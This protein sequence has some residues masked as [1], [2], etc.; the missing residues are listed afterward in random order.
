MRKDVLEEI[1]RVNDL[2]FV[3]LS[4]FVMNQLSELKSRVKNYTRTMDTFL[5]K[6][7]NLRLFSDDQADNNKGFLL[8][9]SIDDENF[10]PFGALNF[11]QSTARDTLLNALKEDSG[12]IFI[13]GVPIEREAVTLA[14]EEI[15]KVREC[16]LN[17][18]PHMKIPAKYLLTV[19][20]ECKEMEDEEL[21]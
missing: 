8:E 15:L 11:V 12:F 17:G 2:P 16:R 10:S 7:E 19:N 14:R 20:G 18:K 1:F 13:E 9:C 5:E 3:D 21:E 4:T 6:G